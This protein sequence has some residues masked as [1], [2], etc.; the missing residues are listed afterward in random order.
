VVW[1]RLEDVFEEFCSYFDGKLAWKA[2][3]TTWSEQVFRF[4][5]EYMTRIQGK[6]L[7]FREVPNLM[8]VDRLW[9]LAGNT[10]EF[11]E[12]ALEHENQPKLESFLQSEIRHL[13]YIKA[14]KKIAITYPNFG[15]EGRVVNGVREEIRRHIRYTHPGNE[16]YLLILGF[17]TRSSGKPA[18]RLKGYIITS[19]GD[20]ERTLDKT[21]VQ[22]REA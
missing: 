3:D 15:Y 10:G 1:I 11:I 9:L 13:V 17:S 8:D 12:L 4:F 19:K 5:S 2:K 16:K 6:S 22:G 21:I 20:A 14:N 7:K 18:I